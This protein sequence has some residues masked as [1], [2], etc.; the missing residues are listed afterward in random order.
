[1]VGGGVIGTPS[2]HRQCICGRGSAQLRRLAFFRSHGWL[3]LPQARD[4]GIFGARTP[5]FAQG[6]RSSPTGGAHLSLRATAVKGNSSASAPYA[7]GPFVGV[8]VCGFSPAFGRAIATW[9]GQA[10][11]YSITAP[12]AHSHSGFPLVGY[13]PRPRFQAQAWAWYA[14]R[15]H[16]L[17][18]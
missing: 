8:C 15:L 9:I 3:F 5:Y 14:R 2:L 11:P 13:G 18:D 10:Q 4:G 12:T 7:A 17:F 16:R 1:M 6:C